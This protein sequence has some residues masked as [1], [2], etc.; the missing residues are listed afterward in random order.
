MVVR[1][2]LAEAVSGGAG[3]GGAGVLAG[4]S[5]EDPAGKNSES[6]P[7]QT[8]LL[9]GAGVGLCRSASGSVRCFSKRRRKREAREVIYYKVYALGLGPR[10][11][12]VQ[13]VPRVPGGGGLQ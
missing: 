11:W 5:G 9:A 1:W 8:C 3:A 10:G 12:V 13:G 2:L 7:V 6:G 4:E